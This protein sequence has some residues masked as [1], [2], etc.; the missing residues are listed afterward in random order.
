MMC[1]CMIWPGFPSW[2][3]KEFWKTFLTKLKEMDL[4]TLF[5]GSSEVL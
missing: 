2:P 3:Q 5:P 4:E 1:L